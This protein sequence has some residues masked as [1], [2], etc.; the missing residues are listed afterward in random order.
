MYLDNF[1]FQGDWLSFSLDILDSVGMQSRKWTANA[2]ASLYIRE[3]LPELSI[4]NVVSVI[5]LS[6]QMLTIVFP[7]SIYFWWMNSLFIY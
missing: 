1:T 5:L 4:Q 2:E 7:D 3:I 6:F